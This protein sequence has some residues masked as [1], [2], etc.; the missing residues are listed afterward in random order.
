MTENY[1]KY[2]SDNENIDLNKDEVYDYVLDRENLK[3][4]DN[5]GPKNQTDFSQAWSDEHFGNL[6]YN[7]LMKNLCLV[8]FIIIVMYLLYSHFC[9]ESS[10][11]PGIYSARLY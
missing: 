4:L 2:N 11:K 6:K 1:Y 7:S 10:V 3:E 5:L 8:I 9:N